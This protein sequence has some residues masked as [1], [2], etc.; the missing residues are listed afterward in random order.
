MKRLIQNLNKIGFCT[1]IRLG[2]FLV[3]VLITALGTLVSIYLQN[4]DQIESMDKLG[5]YIAAN[6][7][8]NSKLGLLSEEP[9]N[10]KQPLDA[11]MAEHQVMGISIYLANGKSLISKK[12]QAYSLSNLKASEQLSLVISSPAPTVVIESE[13]SYDQPLRSY[14]A[15]VMIESSDNDVFN[16]ESAQEKFYG[17]V[18]V[19]MSLQEL[20]VKKAAILQQNLLLIPIYILVGIAFSILIE[21]HIS[22]PLM[23]LKSAVG[24]IAE[25]DF[26]TSINVQ[27]KDEI[28]LLA[29][30]FN[31]MNSQLARTISELNNANASLEKANGE[32]QDFTYIVSHDLQ[33]PLRKV[34]S[35]GQF[36]MEDYREL[37]PEEGKDYVERMQKASLKMK[38]LIQDLLT[39]S[40]IGTAKAEFTAVDTNKLVNEAMDDLY[41]AIEES[42]ADIVVGELPAVQA[43]RTQLKQLFENLIGNAI[44]YRDQERKLKIEIGAKTQNKKVTFMI[45]DNGIGIEDRFFE[46]IFGV[47]QRLHHRGHYKGTGIGLA[48]CKKVIQTHGGK[49]WVE[50]FFGTGT[51]FY[52]T[53]RKSKVSLGASKNER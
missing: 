12:R 9:D 40:R 22:K 3:I 47:F 4:R 19:D 25:G 42:E 13:T 50:S 44:K 17:F 52:F 46:K 6:L 24:A 20:S 31:N 35:F 27:S 7:G 28:G 45:K 33:E 21:R 36:L 49:I 8:Q 37:L 41:V 34:H 23:Q 15:K 26:S 51:T 16:I 30:S 29:E 39:L 2:M 43:N 14:L 18:R 48:L 32:L 10:L 5:R 11:A 53:M 38:E 1:R